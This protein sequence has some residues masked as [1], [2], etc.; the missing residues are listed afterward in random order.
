MNDPR[1]KDM[2][3]VVCLML[4]PKG[5]A[6]GKLHPPT[7]EQYEVLVHKIL[8]N[9]IPAGFDSCSAPRFLEAVKKANFL[10]KEEK[11]SIY[12][13]SDPCESLCF[14]IYVNVE[15]KVFSCSFAEDTPG[16][17]EGISILEC[18]DF[19]KEIWNSPRAQKWREELLSCERK[20]PIYKEIW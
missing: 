14:S 9:N 13:N 1:L 15:G 3:A 6:K 2:G 18:D 17:K 12:T 7:Q 4:K 10:S 20:C 16:Q 8:R 19:L 5:R 11:N